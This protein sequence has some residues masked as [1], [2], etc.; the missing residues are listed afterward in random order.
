MTVMIALVMIQPDMSWSEV[1]AVS[2]SGLFLKRLS[3]FLGREVS[4]NVQVQFD[5]ERMRLAVLPQQNISPRRGHSYRPIARGKTLVFLEIY[6]KKQHVIRR[7]LD[8]YVLHFY[9]LLSCRWRGVEGVEGLK[10]L[11]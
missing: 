4:E 6:P 1:Y 2:P 10:K 7:D 5:A 11:F 9:K 8:F 3:F